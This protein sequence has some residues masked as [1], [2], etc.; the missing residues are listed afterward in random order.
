MAAGTVA[1]FAVQLLVLSD[2]VDMAEKETADPPTLKQ[3]PDPLV[4]HGP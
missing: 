1:L 3:T 2:H 4:E